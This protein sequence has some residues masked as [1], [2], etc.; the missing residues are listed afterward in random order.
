MRAVHLR[1]SEVTYSSDT[2][3]PVIAD[4]EVCV[5][6]LKA[7]ICETDL[8]LAKGYMKFQGIPGHE[9][10]GVAQSGRFAGCR[11]VGEINCPCRTCATCRKGLPR[12]C[13]HRSVVG[14][15]NRNGAFADR[16][17]I[18]E[19]CLHPVP[20]ELS[21]EFA[22]FVEPVAAAC[23]IVEQQLVTSSD[24]VLILGAGRLGNLCAQVLQPLCA[25]LVVVG[26][27]AWKLSRIADCGIRC[28]E[29]ALFTPQPKWD[30]V[31]D[32]TGSPTGLET[33]LQCVRPCGVI[34]LK[35]TVASEQSLHLAPVVIDETRIV[36]SRCGPFEPAL[37]LIVDKRL[38]LAPLISATYGLQDAVEAFRVSGRND[39]LKVQLNIGNMDA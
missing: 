33:A 29:L 23:R 25:D 27:H 7:G 39:V 19:E 2:D 17:A 31:V 8:Q 21:D 13:P 4:G 20:D 16:M 26:K 28:E 5:Q 15:L 24:S 3:E 12:H 14:I 1:D 22:V 38:K 9:F 35:T 11:V 34:V 36:G 32:C 30:V 18:P 6:V 37:E 10:V